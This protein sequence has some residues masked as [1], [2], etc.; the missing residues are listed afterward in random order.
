MGQNKL[1][2]KNCHWNEEKELQ[3]QYFAFKMFVWR[4]TEI[5]EKQRD[6]SFL[7]L[8]V[9]VGTYKIPYLCFYDFEDKASLYKSTY[10][11]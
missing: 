2:Q 4:G 6:V 5:N 8:T 1:V 11:L 10:Y 3:C 9:D 7:C